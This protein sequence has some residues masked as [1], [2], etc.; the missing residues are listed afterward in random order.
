MTADVLRRLDFLFFNSSFLLSLDRHA[1]E[2][3]RNRRAILTFVL[4]VEQLFQL[5][6]QLIRPALFFRGFERIHG[7]A[8]IFPECIH[9][10]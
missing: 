5:F 9:K 4:A 1:Q 3:R 6:L 8:I 7:W 10:R 2:R